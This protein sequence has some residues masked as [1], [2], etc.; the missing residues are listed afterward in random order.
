MTA[1]RSSDICR[2]IGAGGHCERGLLVR[3]SDDGL[4]RAMDCEAVGNMG[5]PFAEID[6]EKAGKA[7]EESRENSIILFLDEQSFRGS[8]SHNIIIVPAH[9]E[10]FFSGR[11]SPADLD[12][13]SSTMHRSMAH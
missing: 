13:M 1:S 5:E 3:L 6:A 2:I 8:A 9:V 12:L 4:N 11:I 10:V 7:R